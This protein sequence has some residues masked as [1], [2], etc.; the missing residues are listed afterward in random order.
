M[1]RFLNEISASDGP[2]SLSNVRRRGVQL[3]SI[4][5]DI[6]SRVLAESRESIRVDNYLNYKCNLLADSM[7]VLIKQY[8]FEIK[9][10]ATV[11]E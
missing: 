11:Q 5:H 3:S 10:L 8:T 1:S 2:L 7:I 6:T 4:A 9:L